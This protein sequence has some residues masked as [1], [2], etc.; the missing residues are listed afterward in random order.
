ME[1]KLV[2]SVGPYNDV[3]KWKHFPC[4]WSFVRG[5]HRSPVNSP[6]KSQ[7]RG[8]LI[9]SFICAWTNVSA[10][11]QDAGDLKSHSNVLQCSVRQGVV[12]E[13]I[14]MLF[15]HNMK[16]SWHGNTFRIADSLWQETTWSAPSHCLNQC[17]ANCLSNKLQWNFNRNT[18][19]FIH[20]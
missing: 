17:W 20:E 11:N 10:N 3:I 1:G 18:K 2:C 15:T 6:H 12:S 13:Y 7:W 19:L 16:T 5:I 4:Y 14:T 9:F 8:A